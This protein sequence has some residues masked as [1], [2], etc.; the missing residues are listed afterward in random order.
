MKHFEFA[1]YVFNN[2]NVHILRSNFDMTKTIVIETIYLFV[3]INVILS[4]FLQISMLLFDMGAYF[5]GN[6]FLPIH[7]NNLFIIF[8]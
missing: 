2:N 1:T 5:I 8:H 6:S 4:L 7:D 3:S